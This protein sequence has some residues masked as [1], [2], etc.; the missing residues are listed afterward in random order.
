MYIVL[1]YL[2]WLSL[3]TLLGGVFFLASAAILLS[4]EGLKIVAVSSRRTATEFME[5][6]SKH[7]SALATSWLRR[8]R[9][10]Q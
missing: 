1:E 10:E 7:V 8:S 2:T 9:Q 6:A 4:R 5:Y 3:V